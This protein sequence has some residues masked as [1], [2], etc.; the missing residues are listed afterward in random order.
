M[1]KPQLSESGKYNNSK[2]DKPDITD[3]NDEPH[4]VVLGRIN[5][6]SLSEYSKQAQPFS[7]IDENRTETKNRDFEE[8]PKHPHLLHIAKISSSE[9]VIDSPI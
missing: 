3:L 4:S 9:N 7:S 2:T 5:L 6:N 1:S 8:G